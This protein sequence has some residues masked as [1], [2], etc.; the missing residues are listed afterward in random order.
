[1]SE[2]ENRV[3]TRH[4]RLHGPLGRRLRLRGIGGFGSRFL[5]WGLGV[6][7]YDYAKKGR[8]CEAGEKLSDAHESPGVLPG[9]RCEAEEEMPP[10]TGGREENAR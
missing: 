1:M 10:G 7:G 6:D 8:E 5:C 3:V 9:M 4:G 2:D